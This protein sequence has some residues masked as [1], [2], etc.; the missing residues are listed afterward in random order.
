MTDLEKL[1]QLKS[2]FVSTVT[3]EFR[4]PLTS[5]KGLWRI[6]SMPSPG[7]QISG[8]RTTLIG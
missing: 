3:H 6:G 5:I 1:N 7:L 8:G 2:C 4:A